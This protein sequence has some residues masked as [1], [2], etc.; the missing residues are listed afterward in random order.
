MKK[1]LSFFGTTIGKKMLVGISGLALAGF[2]FTHMAGNLLLLVSA[3]AYNKYSHALISNPLLPLAEIGLVAMFVLHVALVVQL[4]LRNRA[5]R[6]VSYET[7][8]AGDKRTR[9]IARTLILSGLVVLCF[10]VLHLITF[11][12]GEVYSASYD[13]VEMRDLHRLVV[14]KFKEPLYVGWYVFS[15]M[16]LGAH[17]SHGISGSLQSLSLASANNKGLRRA[18]V[19][20]SALIT[21]GFI[22]QPVYLFFFGA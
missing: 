10:T 7:R 6:D 15:L 22:V 11:K 12:Y 18:S 9:W 14:E 5:A 20:I 4:T 13:G 17:L 8:A 16:V 3:E 21:I 2:L 19:A 1:I